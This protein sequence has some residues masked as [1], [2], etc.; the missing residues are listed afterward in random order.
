MKRYYYIDSE[1]IVS[2]VTIDKTGEYADIVFGIKPFCFIGVGYNLNTFSD[3]Q[4][5]GKIA[6]N[7]FL[8]KNGVFCTSFE[9]RNNSAFFS[10]NLSGSYEVVF[11]KNENLTADLGYSILSE[12]IFE[13]CYM[14]MESDSRSYVL[15]IKS[16]SDRK[17]VL[18]GRHASKI[19]KSYLFSVVFVNPSE[20]YIDDAAFNSN[21]KYSLNFDHVD[22]L[23]G[24][25]FYKP[26]KFETRNGKI[27][28]ISA[29]LRDVG[30]Q[31]SATKVVK[32]K[33]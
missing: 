9:L 4:S 33:G 30:K 25:V 17:I 31:F 20:L 26:V 27:S 15:G 3:L 22:K 28:E 24:T 8:D 5:A 12:N 1:D 32:I 16:N 23:E 29:F 21:T 6:V 11:A 18:E 2:I 13:N 19:L 10:Q 7:E 14:V